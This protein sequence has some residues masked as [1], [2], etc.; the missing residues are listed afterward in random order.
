MELVGWLAISGA[1]ILAVFAPIAHWS[2]MDRSFFDRSPINHAA[3]RRLWI[4]GLFTGTLPL[5]G[6]LWWY[7]VLRDHAAQGRGTTFR[8]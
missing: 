2:R 3:W 1:L 4:I 7:Q 5:M 6:L 8:R